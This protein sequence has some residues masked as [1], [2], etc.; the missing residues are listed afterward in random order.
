MLRTI[1]QALTELHSAKSEAWETNKKLIDSLVY[2][3]ENFP[4]ILAK[5]GKELARRNSYNSSIE[6]LISILIKV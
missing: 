3:V 2:R 5:I 4:R 1:K 6:D